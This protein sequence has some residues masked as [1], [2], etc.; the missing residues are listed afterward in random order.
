MI[1]FGYDVH[2]L[3]EGESFILGGVEIDSKIGTVA[4]SDGDVLVHAIIDALLG[5]SGLGD[6]G[7]LF[8][9]TDEQYANISSMVLLKEVIAALKNEYFKIV[10]IDA[11]IVLEKPKL[12]HYKPEMRKNLAEACGLPERR[13]NIKATTHEKL[14]PFGRGEGVA[15]YAVASLK[16]SN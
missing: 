10:N 11:Q 8:P 13:I 14:G 4:H 1:G 7:E 6:I 5:A 15:V 3:Q 12:L 9:D 2:R 16:L